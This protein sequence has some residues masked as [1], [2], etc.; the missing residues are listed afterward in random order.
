MAQIFINNHFLKSEFTAAKEGVGRLHVAWRL[1]GLV[2]K[3]WR[4]ICFCVHWLMVLLALPLFALYTKFG[5]RDRFLSTRYA[6]RSDK[7]LGVVS[8]VADALNAAVSDEDVV[9]DV[10]VVYGSVKARCSTHH[11][12]RRTIWLVSNVI[13]LEQPPINRG[14]V[15]HEYTSS[16]FRVG[17][18]GFLRENC[19]SMLSPEII[20]HK[21]GDSCMSDAAPQPVVSDDLSRAMIVG[22]LPG[23]A[24]LGGVDIFDWIEQVVV[25]IENTYREI[26]I[27]TPQVGYQN[28]QRRLSKML[29]KRNVTLEVG[30][31]ENKSEAIR[32]A[33]CVFSYSSTFS[34][35]VLRFGIMQCVDSTG[36][37]L[38]GV[39]PTSV[40]YIGASDPVAH[41]PTLIDLETRYTEISAIE[42]NANDFTGAS[43]L[44]RLLVNRLNRVC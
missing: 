44:P 26:V 2:R 1:V 18:N 40:R 13:V 29:C 42:C 19:F 38:F 8:L 12:I 3:I 6:C 30:T 41:Q 31:Y 4:A 39:F 36:S 16:S 43:V 37:F 5:R 20:R 17:L 11:V 27:R 32:S 25:L 35:D 9:K 28:Y 10:W 22:Q 24:S 7:E 15:T 14:V 23:D 34:V 21:E 33:S